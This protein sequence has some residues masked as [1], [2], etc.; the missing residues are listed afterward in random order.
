MDL[1][2]DDYQWA[3]A[4]NNTAGFALISSTTPS[5]D[6]PFNLGEIPIGLPFYNPGIAKIRGSGLV[7]RAGFATTKIGFAYWTLLQYE[8][9]QTTFA[10]ALGVYEGYCTLR[11]RIGANAFSNFNAVMNIPTPDQLEFLAGAQK[12]N[13]PF[14]T[15]TRMVAL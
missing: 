2:A 10:G 13:A 14:L 4:Y 12:Y 15:F 8:Y 1:L 6:E 7:K 5:S 9:L 11:T 3:A